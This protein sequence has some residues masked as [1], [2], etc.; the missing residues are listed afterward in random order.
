LYRNYDKKIIKNRVFFTLIS[1]F[2]YSF[3]FKNYNY[4]IVKEKINYLS[5]SEFLNSLLNS[6]KESENTINNY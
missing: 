2:S 5:G 3:L 6:L 4:A 1:R